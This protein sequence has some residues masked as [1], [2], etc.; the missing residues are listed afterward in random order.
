MSYSIDYSEFGLVCPYCNETT[1]ITITIIQD[2]A[3]CL[4]DTSISSDPYQCDHC[5][6]YIPMETILNQINCFDDY[7]Q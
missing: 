4:V 6:K 1:F 2:N 5:F 7:E 3:T